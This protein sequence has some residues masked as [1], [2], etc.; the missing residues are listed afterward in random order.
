MQ[1]IIPSIQ[2]FAGILRLKGF[3][4]VLLEMRGSIILMRKTLKVYRRKKNIPVPKRTWQNTSEIEH[5]LEI[6]VFQC[7]WAMCP[8]CKK[9]Y[10]DDCNLEISTGY[11]MLD[12][13]KVWKNEHYCH[14]GYLPSLVWQARISAI[15]DGI[16]L[17]RSRYTA[18]IRSVY[19]SLWS[20]KY[21]VT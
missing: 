20:E 10:H 1:L 11:K 19:T 9:I 7:F 4:I 8:S 2:F 5:C 13:L 16:F 6:F 18:L 21:I 3:H 12:I 17:A 15:M 14:S